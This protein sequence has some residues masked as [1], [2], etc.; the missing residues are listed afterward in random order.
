[1]K[2]LIGGIG[3]SLLAT[4][5]II[6]FFTLCTWLGFNVTVV[7]SI[8]LALIINFIP[9]VKK[10]CEPTFERYG[11]NRTLFIT[12][13]GTTGAVYFYAMYGKDIPMVQ[14]YL[15]SFIRMGV[16]LFLAKC[17]KDIMAFLN[18]VKKQR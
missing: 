2:G 9:S 13:I 5:L 11:I 4:L 14:S 6:G 3:S 15:Q 1:M 8:L 7:L 12:M 16:W 17:V 18:E 10:K